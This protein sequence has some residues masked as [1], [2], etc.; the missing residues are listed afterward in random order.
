MRLI[1]HIFAITIGLL[2][3]SSAAFS[4][5]ISM[6][7]TYGGTQYDCGTAVLPTADQGYIFIAET[8]S[9]GPSGCNI[10]MIKTDQNGDTLWTKLFGGEMDDY[11]IK[12]FELPGQGYLIMAT[13][14]SFD[15]STY[16]HL[17]MVDYSG[18]VQ[19][20][21]EDS[22]LQNWAP[23]SAD[24]TDDGYLIIAGS[25]ANDDFSDAVIAKYD[26][27]T[28]HFLWAKTYGIEDY[29]EAANSIIQTADGGLVAAGTQLCDY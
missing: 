28:R 12:I 26:L 6:E 29:A 25:T 15:P 7:R 17:F 20:I 11:P 22:S 3:V 4:Q 9:Y 19:W 16:L 27:E 10:Y 1:N 14:E 18:E 5:Q 23:Y 13:S 2:T 21:N 24:L 8:W